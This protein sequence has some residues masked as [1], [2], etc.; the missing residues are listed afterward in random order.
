MGVDGVT[1]LH[2]VCFVYSC[3][4]PNPRLVGRFGAM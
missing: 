3:A 1:Q 2:L 4:L